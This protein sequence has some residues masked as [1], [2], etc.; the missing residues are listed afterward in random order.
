MAK[1]IWQL[2][3]SPK[4]QTCTRFSPYNFEGFC[5]TMD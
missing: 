5:R 1:T 2:C 4:K 3:Y